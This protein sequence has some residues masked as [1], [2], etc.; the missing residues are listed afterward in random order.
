M[1]VV[2]VGAIVVGPI[3]VQDFRKLETVRCLLW[4]FSEYK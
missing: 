1:R 3:R 4:E 2:G